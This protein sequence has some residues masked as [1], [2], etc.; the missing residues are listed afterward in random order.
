GKFKNGG[1][2]RYVPPSIPGA[3]VDSRFGTEVEFIAPIGGSGGYQGIF[4]HAHG[5]SGATTDF[6]E[7]P[8]V[9][10]WNCIPTQPNFM[11][12][13]TITEVLG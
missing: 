13:G 12:L 11:K 7:A 10:Q 2:T 5:G 6:L 1:I 9:R 3:K 4:K 8:F